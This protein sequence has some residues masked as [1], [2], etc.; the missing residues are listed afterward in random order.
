MTTA[1]TTPS[2]VEKATEPQR[3][4]NL[5]LTPGVRWVRYVEVVLHP[6]LEVDLTKVMID[7]VPDQPTHKHITAARTWLRENLAALSPGEYVPIDVL[8][9]RAVSVQSVTT[10]V[11]DGL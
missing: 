11:V 10:N 9:D 1:T 7:D 4:F 8:A 3:A 5:A 6:G 2:L